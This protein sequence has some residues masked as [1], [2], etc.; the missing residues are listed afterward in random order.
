MF[1][2]TVT[3]LFKVFVGVVIFLIAAHIM[4]HKD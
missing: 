1:A 4:D 3:Q 2:Y